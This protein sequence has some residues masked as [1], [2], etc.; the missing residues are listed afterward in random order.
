MECQYCHKTFSGKPTLIKHQRTVK[1]CLEIQ[2][3]L[4]I[5]IKKLSYTCNVCKKEFTSNNFLYYHAN[6]CSKNNIELQTKFDALKKELDEL[7]EK[8]TTIIQHNNI[9]N[10]INSNNNSIINYM[11]EER[12]LDIFKKNFQIKDLSEKELGKFTVKHILSGE[13]KPVYKCTD[14]SRKKCIYIDQDGKEIVDKNMKVL[15]DLLHQAQP[16]VKEIVQ[17]DIIHQEDEIIIKLRKD[18]KAYINLETDGHEFKSVIA[19]CTLDKPKKPLEDDID[20]NI[21]D[22]FK[23]KVEYSMPIQDDSLDFF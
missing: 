23:E 3:S 8:K 9:V 1:S 11:T 7:K 2:Q 15:I 5:E 18:Y 16:Y 20:W 17:D 19:K 4:G 12:V 10:N 14:L 6:V 13:D 21:N 22:K